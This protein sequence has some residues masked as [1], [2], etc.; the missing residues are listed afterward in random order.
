MICP[1]SLI[2]YNELTLF[3]FKTQQEEINQK[4][5]KS[6]EQSELELE[7]IIHGVELPKKQTNSSVVVRKINKKDDEIKVGFL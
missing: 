7:Y 1:L 6:I 5:S 3:H 2:I 4:N